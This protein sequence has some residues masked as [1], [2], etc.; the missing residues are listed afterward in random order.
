MNAKGGLQEL[1][2][3]QH[4]AMPQ[5][6]TER[7]CGQDHTPQFQSTVIVGAVSETGSLKASKKA[8]EQSAAAKA[9]MFLSSESHS[10][11]ASEN[12][13]LMSRTSQ[14]SVSPARSISPTGSA[15]SL[16]FGQ[17]Q[18]QSQLQ[19]LSLSEPEQKAIP[20]EQYID[21]GVT[22]T[23]LGVQAGQSAKTL[24]QQI[25]VQHGFNA[26]LYMPNRV[27]GSDHQPLWVAT[28]KLPARLGSIKS[29][30]EASK[31]L[32]ETG[33]A[34]GA[35]AHLAQLERNDVPA[36][37]TFACT[38][39]MANFDICISGSSNS[40]A[41]TNDAWLD[42]ID[43]FAS[44]SST[45]RPVETGHSSMH[46]ESPSTTHAMTHQ[47]PNP[48]PQVVD[49][50]EELAAWYEAH[51]QWDFTPTYSEKMLGL[52][53]F[54]GVV[55]LHGGVMI[56]TDAAAP[57]RTKAHKRAA[58]KALAML[59]QSDRDSSL[60]DMK[61]A[62]AASNSGTTWRRHASQHHS[63]ENHHTPEQCSVSSSSS[64][65]VIDTDQKLA[66]RR[67]NLPYATASKPVDIVVDGETMAEC[68]EY[69][70][71]LFN[72]DES[73]FSI[74][75]F[76]AIDS[77]GI[78]AIEPLCELSLALQ[79]VP[80]ECDRDGALHCAISL[81]VGSRL[82]RVEDRHVIV[83]SKNDFGITLTE[84]IEL[85]YE[86]ATCK[87]ITKKSLLRKHLQACGFTHIA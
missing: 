32:A 48:T 51:P 30:I 49:D 34:F 14:L 45:R 22:S 19:S 42:G 66:A 77:E 33:A 65:S 41:I 26:P 16:N 37:L 5:Y 20:A 7:V 70:L 56:E 25:L 59:K 27:G 15:H 81:N 53:G 23:S 1:C 9:L 12:S 80:V 17:Y 11:C 44:Q 28:V 74:L 60:A 3:Q 6:Q 69:V 58:Q 64:S 39:A 57:S 46:P 18:L 78:K 73:K 35:F 21:F 62:G 61:H 24:L 85:D 50:R 83:L 13:V 79:V 2:A 38:A 43:D 84:T 68:V 82:G 55:T 87:L 10:S 40:P 36:S 4:L 54:I 67:P 29:P 75:F 47:L 86:H 72:F 76:A 31:S 8:A 63:S 52:N 71:S